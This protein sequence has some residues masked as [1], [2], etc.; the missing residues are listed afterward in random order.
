MKSSQLV[1]TLIV[2]MLFLPMLASNN[3]SAEEGQLYAMINT[4][5][6][7]IQ[8]RLFEEDAPKTVDNFVRYAKDDFYQGT[9]FHRVISGFMIQGGGF[10]EDLQKKQTPY[11][12]IENEAE[13]SGHRNNRGTIA[14]A[15]TSDPDSATSQF[16]IN[17]VD[18]NKLD[19][20][21][22][23]DGHGY[24]VFGK[25]VDGMDVVDSI[26]SVETETESGMQDVPQQDIV[27]NDISISRES[28]DNSDNGSN[29]IE[30]SDDDSSDGIVSTL[31]SNIILIEVI[32]SVIA[33]VGIFYYLTNKGQ[34][35]KDR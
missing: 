15:R 29:N 12:P 21:K 13:K 20:D 22:A 4:N 24:C 17:T 2:A 9:I 23:R 27:I 3:A 28:V 14:M 34:N 19:W 10:T 33:A 35:E 5:K 16:F 18:N 6:G 30:D 1:I 11:G 26:E 25:V 32:L 7:S 8:I 31:T